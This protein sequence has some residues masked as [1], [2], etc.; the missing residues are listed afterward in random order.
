MASRWRKRKNIW[1]S[2]NKFTMKNFLLILLF[3]S[4]LFSQNK[5][6]V[7]NHGIIAFVKKEM[8]LDNELYNKSLN[9]LKPKMAKAMK[10]QVA[11]EILIEGKKID[12]I[13]LNI[14]VDSMMQNFEFLMQNMNDANQI[15]K[16]YHEFKNDSIIKY[17]TI[18]D[19]IAG[20][21]IYINQS[22]NLATNQLNEYVEL[23]ESEIIKLTEYR[24]E[25][26]TIKGFNCFKVVYDYKEVQTEDFDLLSSVISNIRELWVTE[27]IKCY[28]HPVINESEILEKYY[29]LEI[30]E[31]SDELKGIITSYK[32]EKIEIK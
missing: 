22:S 2:I 18:N 25:T 26:K 8:I 9:D 6:I 13:Q 11:Y 7:P 23:E 19:K 30:I 31:Y 5:A 4:N 16:M 29:P 32:V 10:N 1:E 20:N 28:Y 27:E 21:K 17:Y 24:N 3:T 15:I 12:S 14:L